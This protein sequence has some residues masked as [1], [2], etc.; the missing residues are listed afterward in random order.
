MKEDKRGALT[1]APLMASLRGLC[2]RRVSGANTIFC[3]PLPFAYGPFALGPSAVRRLGCG[4]LTSG[5]PKLAVD[6][7][8]SYSQHTPANVRVQKLRAISADYGS[9][10]T[11][12]GAPRLAPS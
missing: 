12:P 7:G 3:Y 1:R 8:P 5:L 9:S 6:A 10:H 2:L 4:F 11:S